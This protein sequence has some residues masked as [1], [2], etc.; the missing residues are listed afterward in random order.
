MPTSGKISF[1]FQ[2][3]KA[4]WFTTQWSKIS[5]TPRMQCSKIATGVP[6]FMQL[7]KFGWNLLET[8]QYPAFLP[9]PTI[10][11]FILNENCQEYHAE[12]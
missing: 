11:D 9:I 1:S 6:I 4:K 10:S 2:A 3:I 5:E 12:R 7:Q 8:S